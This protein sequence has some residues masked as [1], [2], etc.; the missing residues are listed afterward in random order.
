M[1]RALLIAR[2]EAGELVLSQRGLAW[3]TAMAVVLSVFGLLLVSNTELSLLD[4]AQVVYDMVA[5]VT[6]LGALLALIVGIDTIGGERERGSLVPLLLTPAS[7]GEILLG[8]LGGVAIA[9]IAMLVLAIPYVW[10]IG[11]TGQNLVDAI[12]ALLLLG[13]PVVLG[14]G[15]FGMALGATLSAVRGALIV[16]LIVL[17]L[18]ASPLV[19]GASLRQSAIGQVF[20]AFNPFSAAVNAYD[21]VIIDSQTIAAQWHLLAVA[22]IWL[23][24]TLL[25]ARTRFRRAAG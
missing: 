21:A 5:T 23:A 20:D 10:A 25:A 16:G 24:V 18:A 9:W 4:N 11:S 1:T 22:L 8:K 7:R 19:I 13:T 17:M 14:F 6:A 12:V 3:L 15:F 2:K